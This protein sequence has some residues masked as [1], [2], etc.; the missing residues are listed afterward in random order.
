MKTCHNK[1]CGCTNP[2]N[3]IFC[4]K[5][6]SILKNIEVKSESDDTWRVIATIIIIIIAI[7]IVGGTRGIGTPFAF[8]LAFVIKYIWKKS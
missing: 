6:G 1:V 7:A 8:G 2:D 5:C 4:S 3:A